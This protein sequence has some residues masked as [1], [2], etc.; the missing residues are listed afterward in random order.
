LQNVLRD[1]DF[2]IKKRSED[3]K[4]TDVRN[5]NLDGSDAMSGNINMSG[6]RVTGLA[7]PSA[8]GDASSKQY[9]DGHINSQLNPHVIT[10][11]QIGAVSTTELF[12][13]VGQIKPEKMPDFAV[14]ANI[15]NG[16]IKVIGGAWKLDDSAT[17]LD[18]K[19]SM[20]PYTVNCILKKTELTCGQFNS[21][22]YDGDVIPQFQLYT[23][24]VGDAGARIPEQ[25]KRWVQTEQD[26]PPET[27]PC[28]CV[29]RIMFTVGEI[30][31]YPE[32]S[33]ITW[34]LYRR[35]LQAN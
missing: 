19:Y 10:T 18:C 28:Y 5:L 32:N 25:F 26:W 21:C 23:S 34:Q 11:A 13:E 1:F 27:E 2:A 6:N 33:S 12:D 24:M 8:P 4:M 29:E 7:L 3:S 14:S 17:N 20:N 22:S 31:W 9:V 15:G 16:R 35:T 30:G